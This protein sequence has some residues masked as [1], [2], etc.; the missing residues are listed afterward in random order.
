MEVERFNY[1]KKDS[2]TFVILI[3]MYIC[4]PKDR[5]TNYF[6]SSFG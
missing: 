5:S 1:F 3:F 4:M 2:E 6:Q